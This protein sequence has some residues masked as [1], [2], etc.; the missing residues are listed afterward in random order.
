[1]RGNPPQESLPAFTDAGCGEQ[2]A[3]PVVLAMAAKMISN[4][5]THLF[6]TPVDAAFAACVLPEQSQ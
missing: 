1:M 4:Y 5:T 3:L 2:Q 6:D